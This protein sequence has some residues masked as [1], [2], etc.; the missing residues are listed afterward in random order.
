MPDAVSDAL[1]PPGA[2]PPPASTPPA[3]PPPDADDDRPLPRVVRFAMLLGPLA[4]LVAAYVLLR[5]VAGAQRAEEMAAAAGASFAGL[6]TTVIFG[7]AVLGAS[8]FQHLSSLD[9]ALVVLGLNTALAFVFVG[10]SDLLERLPWVGA[11]VTRARHE[12]RA[13]AHARPWVRRWAAAG[14]T[15][16][17]ISPL[18]GSG[19]FGGTVVGR[20]AGLSRVATLVAVLVANAVVCGIY[21]FGADALARWTE[22]HQ[23]SLVERLG[24]FL[25]FAVVMIWIMRRLFG[26]NKRPAPSEPR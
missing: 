4:A 11:F 13:T 19:V 17:V 3:S 26:P 15:L 16:F 2:S 1:G 12:A 9:L 7:A 6:G 23:I 21:F 10:A 25:G 5:G 20:I 22:R 18:P 8:G 24:A 14:V